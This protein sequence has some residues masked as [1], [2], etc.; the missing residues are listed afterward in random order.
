VASVA[1]LSVKKKNSAESVLTV[2]SVRV[3]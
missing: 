2:S 3:V 1:L